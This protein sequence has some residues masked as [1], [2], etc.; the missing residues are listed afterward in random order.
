MD[1]TACRGIL[2]P[3]IVEAAGEKDANVAIRLLDGPN[4]TMSNLAAN[5]E[6]SRF[7]SA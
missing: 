6:D 1:R 5:H 3:R 2:A 4:V 7:V